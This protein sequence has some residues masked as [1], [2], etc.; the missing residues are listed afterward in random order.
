MLGPNILPVQANTAQH[1]CHMTYDVFHKTYTTS[2]PNTTIN[3][4]VV[5]IELITAIHNIIHPVCYN[6]YLLMLHFCN[7]EFRTGVQACTDQDAT[8]SQTCKQGSTSNST[9]CG[10]QD[11]TAMHILNTSWAQIVCSVM[12]RIHGMLLFGAINIISYHIT[13]TDTTVLALWM[14]SNCGHCTFRGKQAVNNQ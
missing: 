12:K 14:T 5:V 2:S 6:L 1:Q 8:Y 4:S 7:V 3:L 11:T 10:L 13:H 9:L